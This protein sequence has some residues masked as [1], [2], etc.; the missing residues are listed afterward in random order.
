MQKN[1]RWMPKEHRFYHNCTD[2]R[3]ISD[4]ITGI[5][6]ILD[7]GKNTARHE[8]HTEGGASMGDLYWPIGTILVRHEKRR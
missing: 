3:V 1:N 2:R 7:W 8:L 4:T 6:E 5:R